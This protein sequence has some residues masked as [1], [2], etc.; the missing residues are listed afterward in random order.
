MTM[1]KTRRDPGE[2]SGENESK[3]EREKRERER[4]RVPL[5]IFM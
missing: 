1:E 3:R 5:A 4:E 2:T